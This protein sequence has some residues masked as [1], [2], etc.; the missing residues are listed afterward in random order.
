MYLKSEKFEG[1]KIWFEK[2]GNAVWA[3]VRVNGR[4]YSVVEPTK[5]KASKAI[6]RKI[7]FE[8]R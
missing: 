3:K 5:E 6:K 8:L 2:S 1:H 4:W 7:W